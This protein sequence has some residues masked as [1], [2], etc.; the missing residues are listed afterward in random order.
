[1]RRRKSLQG[2]TLLELL[3]TLTLSVF[4]SVVIVRAAGF[5]MEEQR[6]IDAQRASVDQSQTLERELTKT[7]SGALLD[8]SLI[9]SDAT[10]TTAAATTGPATFFQSVDEGSQAD[11]GGES[12]ITFTTTMPVPLSAIDNQNDDWTT[13]QTNYGPVGGPVEV[14]IGITP[15]GS[16][17]ISESGL[18]E[19]IQHPSDSDPT[20]GGTER[21]LDPD[22]T[23]IGFQFWDGE[24]W[25]PSWDTTTM[26]AVHLPQAVQVTYRL[27]ADIGNTDHVFVIPILSSDVNYNNP[28]QPTQ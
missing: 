1:V 20:Q 8:S 15:I 9:A 6:S 11:G 14:S 18:F 16:P 27:K 21:L 22:V 4:L 7:I 5:E 2:L 26:T 13:Q 25:E 28:V 3:L 19:R 12:R 10:A 23:S 24:E 17:P